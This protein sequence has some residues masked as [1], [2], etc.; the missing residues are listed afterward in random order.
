MQFYSPSGYIESAN[1]NC[2]FLI[3]WLL[4]IDEIVIVKISLFPFSS[5]KVLG[6]ENWILR[7]SIESG[8]FLMWQLIVFSPKLTI[9]KERIMSSWFSLNST[10]LPQESSSS[11]EGEEEGEKVRVEKLWDDFA[12][13][14]PPEIF[15][16]ISWT[17]KVNELSTLEEG[18]GINKMPKTT[19]ITE[20]INIGTTR[21]SL[22]LSLFK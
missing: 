20:R 4:L 21:I 18:R 22:A 8:L 19:N 5:E 17:L 14:M 6:C 2:A 10:A 16:E 1:S 13:V 11:F 15:A 3:S 7:F 9:V 12:P